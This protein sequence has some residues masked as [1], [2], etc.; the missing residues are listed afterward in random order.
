MTWTTV[1]PGI[2]RQGESETLHVRVSVDGRR[3]FRSTRTTSI[4]EARRFKRDLEAK[5]TMKLDTGSAHRVKVADLRPLL[6]AHYRGARGGARALRGFAAVEQRLGALR[7]GDVQYDVLSRYVADRRD[8]GLADGTIRNELA[9]LRVGLKILQRARKLHV[10]PAFPKL[11]PSEARQGFFEREAFDAVRDQLPAPLRP[12]ATFYYLTGWRRREALTR[13]WRHVDWTAQTIRLDHGETKNGRPRL[14]PFGQ[15]PELRAVMEHQREETKRW[16]CAR[17]EVIPWVFH[18]KGREIKDYYGAWRAACER[19]GY[20]GKL[21]HDFRR[22]ACRNLIR[23]GVPERVAMELTGHTT[24]AVFDRYNIVN[25][26]DLERAAAALG[27]VARVR[28]TADRE[29][30]VINA[31]FSRRE[32]RA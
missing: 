12:L 19:A 10:L 3:V 22:T 13:Q 16:E 14:F 6:E 29:T 20:P 21:V 24:R 28:E 31:S 7:V 18:R 17:G 5:L 2:Y 30:P 9:P 4:V 8:A 11:Q 25:T 23:A 15:L 1:E 26:A 27:N 32:A